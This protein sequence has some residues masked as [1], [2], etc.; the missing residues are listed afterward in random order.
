MKVLKGFYIFLLI[1]CFVYL[2]MG[3]ETEESIYYF[4]LI[5]LIGISPYLI[6]KWS[7]KKKKKAIG[8]Y[9][10]VAIILGLLLY[11]N[12]VYVKCNRITAEY[13]RRQA[14]YE[15]SLHTVYF[16]TDG[17]NSIEPIRV[18]KFSDISNVRAVKE[19]YQF[20]CWLLAG[21]PIEYSSEKLT[22]DITLTASY[23]SLKPT[24][25]E[26]ASAKTIDYVTLFKKGEYGEIYKI[27][28]EIVQTVKSNI[29]H[30]NMTDK[31]IYYKD[32]IEIEIKG[33]PSE[34]LMNGDI[35]S[36]KGKYLGNTKI[37]YTYEIIP[38]FEVYAEN[39][40]ITGHID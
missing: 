20:I 8:V 28:G 29:Y 35:I 32:R 6:Y 15:A 31:G 17:G 9:V 21:E 36:F 12:N 3:I 10:T 22:Q 25:E 34:I 4:L 30:V 19:E 24:R 5:I 14:E 37:E 33:T 13:E 16:D 18:Q 40:K 11:A 2:R 26:L 23:K 38:S 1:L 27:T 39:L 7:K